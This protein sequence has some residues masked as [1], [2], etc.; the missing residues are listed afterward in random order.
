MKSKLFL[1]VCLLWAFISEAKT[2]AISYFDNSSGDAKYNALSKGISDMLITDLSKVKGVTIVEREKLEKLL[3]EIKLGQSKYFDQTTAVKLGKGLGAQNIL[4]GSFYILD[5]IIRLDARLIDVQTGGVIFAEQVSGNKNNFFSLH[6][7]LANLLAKSINIPYSPDLSGLYK[8]NEQ[9]SINEVVNYSNAIEL[10]DV[11][12]DLEAKLLLE[13]TVKS[14]PKFQFAKYKLDEIKDLIKKIEAEREKLILEELKNTI[15]TID[16]SNEKFGMQLTNVWTTLVSSYKFNQLLSFNNSIRKMKVDDKKKIYGEAS[17]YTLGEM[18]SFYDCYAFDALK[19]YDL[20]IDEGKSFITKYPTSMYFQSVKMYLEKAIKEIEWR[21]NAKK[22]LDNKLAAESLDAYVNYLN[23]LEWKTNLQFVNTKE[24]QNYAQIYKTQVLNTNKETIAIWDESSKFNEF[25]N[26]FE[27]AQNY[28]DIK[29]MED[30]VSTSKNLFTDPDDQEKVYSL[31]NKLEDFKTKTIENETKI[32]ELESIAKKGSK[33]EMENVIHWLFSN[34][35]Y[36]RPDLLL[37]ICDKYL[38]TGKPTTEKEVDENLH[39]WDGFIMYTGKLK[40]IEDANKAFENLKSK[41][42]DYKAFQKDYDK[43]VREINKDFRSLQ[44][45]YTS[46]LKKL[47]HKDPMCNVLENYAS[48]YNENHQYIDEVYTRK[49]ILELYKLDDDKKSLQLFL[50]MMSYYNL[51]NF[52][53]VRKTA[54]L[55]NELYPTGSYAESI[56]SIVDFLPK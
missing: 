46:Y 12:M 1:I 35:Q 21:E 44:N 5:N 55:Y 20:V 6:Q 56:K 38:K 8:T 16:A 4:T 39:A 53:N 15:N 27:I 51:G 41:A 7:Q 47:K 40:N 11:G 14:N 26:F 34:E 48:T 52:D 24:Y 30:I 13:K 54:T 49:Q 37:E 2:I 23:N 25:T 32:K 33:H 36:N 22:G 50:L 42:D 3:Q 17:P 31:E 18:L 29:M 45:D 19:K 43:K 9:V 10:Q 28:N